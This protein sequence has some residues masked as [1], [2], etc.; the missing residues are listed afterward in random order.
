MACCGDR[1]RQVATWRSTTSA[2]ARSVTRPVVP[3]RATTVLRYAGDAPV[4]FTG[5]VSGQ[6]YRIT[7][8]AREVAADERDVPALIAT[9]RFARI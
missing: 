5:P 7:D 6:R 3:P 2:T 8:E 4:A 9:R 1:R